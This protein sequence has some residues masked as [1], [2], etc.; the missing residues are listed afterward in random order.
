MLD[1]LSYPT[2]TSPDRSS[3]ELKVLNLPVT[4]DFPNF[5][6]VNYLPF[7]T[8]SPTWA[9]RNR[10]LDLKYTNGHFSNPTHFSYDILR[11]D[12]KYDYDLMDFLRKELPGFSEGSPTDV[13][14]YTYRGRS[15]VFYLNEQV[16]NWRLLPTH[17][18]EI[19]YVKVMEDFI[20][21]DNFIRMVSEIPPIDS[22]GKIKNPK[23][24]EACIP[25]AMIC[26]YTRKD[27]D[28]HFLKGEMSILTVKGYD[29]P[30]KWMAADRNT[31]LWEPYISQNRYRFSIPVADAGVFKV[32]VNGV[33]PSGE[34]FHFEKIIDQSGKKT[35]FA[36]LR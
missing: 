25:G 34:T 33:N 2:F 8:I 14:R 24:K 6:T 22:I 29:R 10:E 21:D 1:S 9:D 18:D 12:T 31:L 23:C 28:F 3:Y 7:V 30:L 15:V 16:I 17:F 27:E 4:S 13:P 11:T 35:D 36:G 5:D 20:N 26:I 19:A 32:V